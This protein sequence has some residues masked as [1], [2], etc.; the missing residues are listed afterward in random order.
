MI[1]FGQKIRTIRKQKGIGLNALAD[2]L[3]ISS[4]YLSNLET[5]KTDTIQLSL[6]PK[7]Q[8]ELNLTFDEFYTSEK[9]DECFNEFEYRIKRMSV[10]LNELDKQDPK[11]AQYLLSTVEQGIDLF[12]RG[13]QGY[14]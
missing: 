11:V 12:H 4:G 3:E 8:E 2:K 13:V 10:L 7:L 5:G 14:H 9:T 6:I 1:E